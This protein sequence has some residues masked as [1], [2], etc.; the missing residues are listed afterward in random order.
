MG[1]S[2]QSEVGRLR[3]AIIHWP[4]LELSRLTPQNI[5]SLLFHDVM[6]AEKARREHDVFA[7]ILRDHGVRVHY[8]GQLLAETLDLPE[9]LA[10]AGPPAAVLG[11]AASYR[12]CRHPSP[13]DPPRTRPG[14]GR[15][16]GGYTYRTGTGR[17]VTKP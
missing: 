5:A 12:R 14:R 1:F 15:G 11:R 7:E 13:P 17:K 2:V 8:F 4:G 3:Q 16:R 9:G 6:W 10:P